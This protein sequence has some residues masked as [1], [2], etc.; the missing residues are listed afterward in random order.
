M[1][2]DPPPPPPPDVPDLDPKRPNFAGLSLKE[3]LELHR[4]KEACNNCHRG[5]D[6]WGVAFESYAAVGLW[7]TEVR[8]RNRKPVP[9]D[10]SFTLPDGNELKGVQQ[11]Q[12]YLLTHKRQRFARSIVKRLLTYGLGRSVELA[13]QATVDELTAQFEKEDYRLGKLIAD[14]VVSRPFQTK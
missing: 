12:D 10:T 7:R 9:V 4:E 5:I 14:I 1:L 13:D 11:L 3:Q 2:D 8:G 6:P